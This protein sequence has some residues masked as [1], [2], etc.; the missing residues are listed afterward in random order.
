MGMKMGSIIVTKKCVICGKIEQMVSRLDMCLAC[1][2][3]EQKEHTR[4]RKSKYYFD[5]RDKFREY[6]KQ[7]YKRKQLKKAEGC[8]KNMFSQKTTVHYEKTEGGYYWKAYFRNPVTDR[9][10]KFESG[11]FFENIKDAQKD[12]HEATK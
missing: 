6:A 2:L 12:Y 11:R 10:V 5:N 1:R 8:K 9:L 7:Y 3:K 4:N